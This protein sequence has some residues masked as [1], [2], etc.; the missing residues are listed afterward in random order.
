M[1]QRVDYTSISDATNPSGSSAYSG[2]SVGFRNEERDDTI[3]KRV[4]E[5]DFI[6]SNRPGG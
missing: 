6:R 4:F 1:E 3:R 5:G 2:R